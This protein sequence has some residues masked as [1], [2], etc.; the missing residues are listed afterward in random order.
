MHPPQK[1]EKKV[2]KIRVQADLGKLSAAPEPGGDCK[3]CGVW[4]GMC[5]VLSTAEADI[6]TMK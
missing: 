3:P 5:C 1:D 4:P 6:Q 2:G